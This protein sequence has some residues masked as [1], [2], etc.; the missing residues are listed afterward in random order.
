MKNSTT[1]LTISSFLVKQ[2]MKKAETDFLFETCH[3]LVRNNHREQ[4]RCKLD[5]DLQSVQNK[6]HHLVSNRQ[7]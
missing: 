1:A 3:A 6:R 7:E 4:A 5:A 2:K